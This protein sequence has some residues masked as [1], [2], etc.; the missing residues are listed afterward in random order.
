M[1]AT[2]IE[3]VLRRFYRI[4]K[5][6]GR[7][8]EHDYETR[9]TRAEGTGK[10]AGDTGFVI[11]Y[12]AMPLDLMAPGRL[13]R[14]L[15]DVG[16]VNVD[17]VDHSENMRPILRLFYWMA[18]LPYFFAKLLRLDW[19]FIDTIAGVGGMAGQEHWKYLSTSLLARGSP[20]VL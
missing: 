3:T 8:V 15:E 14:A 1:H 5:P 12:S 17:I 4:L 6:C 13:R 19:F 10:L 7:L 20:V 11:K 18:I 2:D 16:F 9:V